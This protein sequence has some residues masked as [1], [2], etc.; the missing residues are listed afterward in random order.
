MSPRANTTLENGPQTP[1]EA[2]EKLSLEWFFNP[3]QRARSRAPVLQA[4]KIYL[5]GEE[6]GIIDCDNGLPLFSSRGQ[7]WVEK[8][9][10][11]SIMYKEICERSE[12][13]NAGYN[14]TRNL[15]GASPFALP[16]IGLVEESFESFLGSK[17]RPNFPLLEPD[18]FRET[19]RD[20]YCRTDISPLRLLGAK[21]CVAT[22][23]AFEAIF[24]LD[25]ARDPPVDFEVYISAAENALPHLIPAMHLDG[26]Q[27]CIILVSI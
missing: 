8:R 25:V 10:G 3:N 19:I 11:E 5:D 16:H 22:F 15:N 12:T 7:S 18:L 17:T 23:L 13:P 1:N 4:G 20:A 26:Y 6:L 9:S 27:A 14:H 21:I 2:P 24:N